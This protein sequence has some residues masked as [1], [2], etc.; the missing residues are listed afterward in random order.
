MP[1]RPKLEMARNFWDEMGRGREKGMHCP[2]P[3]GSQII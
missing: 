2:M 3:S 1:V